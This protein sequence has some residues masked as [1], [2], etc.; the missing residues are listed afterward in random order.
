M[1]FPTNASLIFLTDELTNNRYLV[2]T[3]ATMSIVPCNKN[4]NPSGKMGWKGQMGS[5]SPLGVSFKKLCN[6]KAS[7]SHPH[8]CKQLWLVPSWALTF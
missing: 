8:F 6:F 7:F 4:S 3:G 1:H 5:L 2:D